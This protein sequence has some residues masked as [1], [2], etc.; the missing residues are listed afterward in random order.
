MKSKAKKALA[1]D[2][3]ERM[4]TGGGSFI[5]QLDA[6]D[7]R[8]IALLGHRATPL[9]NVFDSDANYNNETGNF[10]SIS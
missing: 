6:V 1:T 4:R 3:V 8:M 5:P 7:E 9:I 2:K 10:L